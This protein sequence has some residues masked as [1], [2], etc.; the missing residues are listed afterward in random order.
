MPCPR[1][2]NATSRNSSASALSY[3]LAQHRWFC[4]H[5]WM[6]RIGWASAGP[7]SRTCSRRPPPPVTVWM[8]SCAASVVMA[9]SCGPEAERASGGAT[10]SAQLTCVSAEGGILTRMA[11]VGR[12]GELEELERALAGAR[13]GR[14]GAVLVTGDAG[15]GKTRLVSELASRAGD[16]DVLLGQALDLVGTE[17]PFQPFVDALGDLGRGG[18]RLEVFETALARLTQRPAPALLILED[19]HWADRST[20][21]LVVY[22][23]H[24]L[25]DRRAQLLATARADEPVRLDRLAAALRR[26]GRVLA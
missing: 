1:R 2:S 8:R 26:S 6:K 16:F 18:S 13:A 17:L 12:A 22:L 20:L 25:H 9:R 3:C 4:D 23:G 21:D 7:H 15:I 11:F 10:Y 5:P 24:R 14:G 19:L